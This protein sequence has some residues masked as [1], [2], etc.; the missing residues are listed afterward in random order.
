MLGHSPLLGWSAGRTPYAERDET[1]PFSTGGGRGNLKRVVQDD[2]SAARQQRPL[3][4]RDARW[5]GMH[6]SQRLRGVSLAH[7]F[8]DVVA[9]DLR[10]QPEL[11]DG[12]ELL[13]RW[14]PVQPAGAACG[15]SR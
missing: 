9:H 3:P 13:R 14:P 4:P 1:C 10:V 7:L 2:D 6:P 11:L 8:A 15:A 5:S 12:P